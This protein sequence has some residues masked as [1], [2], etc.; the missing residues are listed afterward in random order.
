MGR[1]RR[2]TDT[3][4]IERL[5]ARRADI[6]Q[7][8]LTRMHSI[9]DP[10]D[11]ADP[12][13]SDGLRT[14][15]GAALTH[16]LDTLSQGLGPA[17]SPPS[18][19]LVQAGLAARSGVGLDTVIRR[20][21]CGHSI[22][23][24]IL[25][26]EVGQGR[27]DPNELKLLLRRVSTALDHLL[28]A[29]SDEY[30]RQA[31]KRPVSLEQRRA[32][33]VRALLEGEL[34]DTSEFNYEF[35]GHHLAFVATGE[36]VQTAISDLAASLDRRLLIVRPGEGTTWGWLGGRRPLDPTAVIG[37]RTGWPM[38]ARVAFGEP[39][40]GLAGWRLSHRQAVAALPTATGHARTLVR[41][42]DVALAAAALQDEVLAVS[43]RKLYLAPLQRERDGGVAAE[44]TLRRYF[45]TGR[46]V[47]S[48]AASLGVTRNTV[49][50]RLRSV[51]EKIGE[52]LTSCAA[53][54]ETALMMKK[55]APQKVR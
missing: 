9:S 19:L 38:E 39:A 36:G 50:N 49:T 12:S 40:S 45:G 55:V 54:L 30:Q 48:A 6:E 47:S 5:R 44:E 2:S 14:A 11:V 18:A 17:P 4:L 15:V 26:E 23:S 27:L 7:A 8:V 10:A 22:F 43:L 52:P 29:V 35:E 37:D 1:P 33:Q 34:V 13:Y 41:Y 3:E 20:Y 51:E 25:V 46:N 53:L 31:V 42:R 32:R 28:A 21:I 24:D 16:W